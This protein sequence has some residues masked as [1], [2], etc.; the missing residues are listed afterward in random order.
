VLLSNDRDTAVKLEATATVEAAAGSATASHEVGGSGVKS[1]SGGGAAV[2]LDGP[3]VSIN[4][5]AL[6]VS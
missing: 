1:A 6:K 5:G 2:D 4:N 3:G